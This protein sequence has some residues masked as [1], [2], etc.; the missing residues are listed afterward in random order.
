MDVW[1]NGR[2]Q[3][4][5]ELR[6]VCDRIGI[7]LAAGNNNSPIFQR[8][9]LTLAELDHENNAFVSREEL[10]LLRERSARVDVLED[11]VSSLS[12]QK[13]M[14]VKI[15][16]RLAEK[17]ETN[18]SASSQVDGLK[19]E[20]ERLVAELK[21]LSA[22]PK[23]LL[24]TPGL[25]IADG[26]LTSTPIS[27]PSEP[28]YSA[29]RIDPDGSQVIAKDAYE[30]LVKKFN[31]VYENNQLLMS[32]REKLEKAL[33][34]RKDK[35][36]ENYETLDKRVKKREATIKRQEE[37]LQQ[38]RAQLQNAHGENNV[39]SAPTLEQVGEQE[40]SRAFSFQDGRA[41][42][43]RLPMLL[44]G[45]DIGA[46][47]NIDAEFAAL[48]PSTT[49][50]LSPC[51][52]H[53]DCGES[54]VKGR[55]SA[56]A[57]PSPDTPV[58][59]SSKIV[60]KARSRKETTEPSKT[61]RVKIETI[62][63]S[64]IGLAALFALDESL[65]LDD[66]GDNQSTPRK[67][68]PFLQ[69][70]LRISS[71]IANAARTETRTPKRIES[72]DSITSQV[73]HGATRASSVLQPRSPNLRIL[74]RTSGER[75]QKR[76]RITSDQAMNDLLEDGQGLQ[77]IENSGKTNTPTPG[78]ARILPDLL[79][80]PSPP[81]Q[82]LTSTRLT[83][84]QPKPGYF[85]GAPA[86]LSHACQIPRDG[87]LNL[88]NVD[89]PLST[90]LI[91]SKESAEPPT[92]TFKGSARSPKDTSRPPSRGSLTGA[93]E[94]LG[95]A[96]RTA[97]RDFGYESRP[98]STDFLETRLEI[99]N[100]PQPSLTNPEHTQRPSSRNTLK[101]SVEPQRPLSTES[102]EQP[103]FS[104]L[105]VKAAQTHLKDQFV[106][107]SR[108]RNPPLR[109]RPLEELTPQD[110]KVNPKNNQGYGYAFREVVRKQADR[111]CLP[112]CTK[113]DCC[114]D[115]FR[116]LAEATR[117]PNKTRTASQEEADE[118]ILEEFLG[119]NSSKI[120]TMSKGERHE[121]LIQ[122]LA[123]DMSNKMGKHRH[124][125]ERRQSPPGYWRSDF[126]NTQEQVQD[127]EKTRQL[128]QEQVKH[129]YE[130]AMRGGAYIFQ[131][132]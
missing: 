2:E 36:R 104:K 79:A 103:K 117:D 82:V 17:L 113:P 21:R 106:T 128:E 87:T 109:T 78:Q 121:I 63:S 110:F 90:G 100:H 97:L 98:T 131:D 38:M 48:E 58:V 41:S 4:A 118:K 25:Q 101:A 33:T 111:R 15:K 46:L 9:G 120:W 6:R 125:Y 66:I 81:K 23:H 129:R 70:A 88:E 59:V 116:I 24:G 44:P 1:Q 43:S 37:E 29:S 55:T 80:N 12:R 93:V 42:P 50:D 84:A 8:R 108:T 22:D 26:S 73:L 39:S 119:D 57:S 94:P 83:P 114:G 99:L 28:P 19:K 95:P 130:E 62:S 53:A 71:S 85:G 89:P 75:L 126:P 132:E 14:L 54:K 49:S 27:I 74:P 105:A 5:E 68:R 3:L 20:N 45:N 34:E 122:A 31:R 11:V 64:P 92:A 102:T 52:P 91:R 16:A 18:K 51:T 77:L 10:R 35:Y 69:Q 76:R 124:A 65:D 13:D 107:P 40:K 47:K 115:Q 127:R 72:D 67:S 30:A 96:S 56:D 7:N 32:A 60:R 112:G 86:V 61:P 123:R